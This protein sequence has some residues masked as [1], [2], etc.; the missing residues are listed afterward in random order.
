[1]LRDRRY[2]IQLVNTGRL[3]DVGRDGLTVQQTSER[4]LRSQQW[5]FEPTSDGYYYIR[6][7]ET[8]R[9]MTAEGD[10]NGASVVVAQQLRGRDNQLWEVRPG[11]DNGYYLVSKLGRALD[12][13]SSARGEGGRMQLYS[14]NGEANQRFRLR[15]I[16]YVPEPDYGGAGAGSVR[17]RGR[18]DDVVHLEVRGNTITERRVSGSSFDNGRYTFTSPFP[19]R[20]ATLSL[21]RRKARGSVEIIER[22]SAYNNYT[23]I[24][25]IRDPQGGAADYEFDLRWN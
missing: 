23:A 7:V 4:G 10:R 11:P 9:V 3:L 20:E 17:W 12:S 8:G 13:P 2:E 18:V 24:I 6:S 25:E 16:A 14:A 15:A 5:D 1:V 21:D 19:R 22:P